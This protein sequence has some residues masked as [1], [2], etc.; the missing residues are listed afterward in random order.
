MS[1]KKTNNTVKENVNYTSRTSPIQ[2]NLESRN[3]KC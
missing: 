3:M 1:P 2:N